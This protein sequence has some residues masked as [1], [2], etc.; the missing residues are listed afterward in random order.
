MMAFDLETYQD[1]VCIPWLPPCEAPGNYKKQEAID[2]FV[3]EATVARNAKL[4]LHPATCRIVSIGWTFLP[5]AAVVHTCPTIDAERL[6]LELFWQ[7]WQMPGAMPVGFNCVGFDLPVLLIRSILLGCD[8]PH[9]ILRKYGSPDC[10][11]LML[12]LSLGGM[13]DYKSLDFWCRRLN[14]PVS[15][16]TTSG[17]D[18]A[19]FVEAGD[20]AA[21][22]AHNRVDVIKTFALAQRLY[23]ALCVAPEAF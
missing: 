3:A 1:P 18:I 20:W 22:E 19:A 2:A 13:V 5:D 9:L 11:D 7:T 23:P 15:E 6:A 16:D 4:A 8:R 21:I 17:K 14:L 10:H 12:D